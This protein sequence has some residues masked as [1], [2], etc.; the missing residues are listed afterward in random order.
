MKK[1]Q[2]NLNFLKISLFRWLEV[3]LFVWIPAVRI[4][5][6]IRYVSEEYIR[7]N[8]M[9]SWSNW[10]R[11][12]FFLFVCNEVDFKTDFSS[13]LLIFDWVLIY[14]LLV[15]CHEEKCLHKKFKQHKTVIF[16]Q[17][18]CWEFKK[19]KM[20]LLSDKSR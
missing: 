7:L 8:F 15:F 18:G 16:M 20:K 5:L 10:Q 17:F 2:K 9:L 1:S 3:A 19:K 11:T 14:N 4:I 12:F 6:G 13:S